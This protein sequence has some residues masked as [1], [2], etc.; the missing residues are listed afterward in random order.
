M[1]VQKI[2]LSTTISLW[3]G[4]GFYRGYE[5]CENKI[6]KFK[7]I[8]YGFCGMFIYLNPIALPIMLEAEYKNLRS[9]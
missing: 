7:T 1:N 3:S 8:G 4:L 6:N 9:K 5:S 2:C